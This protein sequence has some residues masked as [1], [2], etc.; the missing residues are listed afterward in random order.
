MAKDKTQDSTF[1]DELMGFNPSEVAAFNEPE[2]KAN[3]NEN[4]YKTNPKMVDTKEV[5]DGHYRAKLRILYNPYDMKQSIV[6]NAHYSFNDA[7]GFFMLDSKLALG[8]RSCKI[9][10]D[11]KSLH[12]NQSEEKVEIDGKKYTPKEWGDSI[13]DKSESD[14]VLVQVIEDANQPD[15]VGKFLGWRLPKFVFDTMQA[16]MN[17]TDKSKTPQDLMNYLFGPVLDL[18]V[19]PGPDDP[20]HPERKQREIS[21][22]L[23]SFDNDPTPIIAV[24]GEDLFSDEERD[25][26]SDYAAAKAVITNAKSTAKKRDEAMAKCKELVEPLKVLI[27]KAKT[28]VKE[29]AINVFDEFGYHEP[30][31]E[32]W[33]RYDKWFTLVK[34]FKNPQTYQE[35]TTAQTEIPTEAPTPVPAEKKDES[36][37]LPF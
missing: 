29:N 21:Y 11:W 15:K 3:V 5:P 18:D 20:A 2:K 22:K 16:K 25:M 30:T 13:F 28:Y 9:F 6:K 7:N 26:I 4:L 17:P 37:D 8:D 19:A 34:D 32:Q 12:F 33:A 23:S 24:T 10:K 36:D 31:A 35:V 1:V 14:Y 27:E